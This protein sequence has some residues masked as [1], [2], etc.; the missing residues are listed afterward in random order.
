[1]RGKFRNNWEQPQPFASGKVVVN[2]DLPDVNPHIPP[3][4]PHH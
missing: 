2:F 4:T 1:M 3:R